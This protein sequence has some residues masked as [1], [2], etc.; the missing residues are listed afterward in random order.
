MLDEGPK[1]CINFSKARTKCCLSLQYNGDNSYLWKNSSFYGR[2]IFKSKAIKMLSF[3]LSLVSE[4]Y[5]MDLELLILE[6]Y[7]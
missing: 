6:E 2:E 5:L 1:F 7:L 3:Q 4:A